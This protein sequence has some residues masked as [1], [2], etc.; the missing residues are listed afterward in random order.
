M[1]RSLV[2]V[3]V[4]IGFVAGCAAPG[5]D[6]AQQVSPSAP[7]AASR[8]T[9]GELMAQGGRQL[10]AAE[11]KELHTGATIQG[12]NQAGTWTRRQGADGKYSGQNSH[13]M[14]GSRNF[15]G[16]WHIDEKGRNCSL[17][18]SQRDA[19]LSCS[20]YYSLNGK[21]YTAPGEEPTAGTV[22]EDRTISR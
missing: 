20:H 16:D 15:N 9:V 6:S 13:R 19:K 2:V 22:L 8:L 3:L 1:N 11:M 18:R 7:A 14:G 12:S 10:T 21:Y 5:G 4:A 17:N